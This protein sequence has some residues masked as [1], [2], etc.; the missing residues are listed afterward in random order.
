MIHGGFD[1]YSKRPSAEEPAPPN[2]EQWAGLCVREVLFHNRSSRLRAA[3]T[4]QSGMRSL[5]VSCLVPSPAHYFTSAALNQDSH[6]EFSAEVSTAGVFCACRLMPSPRAGHGR[7]GAFIGQSHPF[8]PGRPTHGVGFECVSRPSD[9]N[10]T[11]VRKSIARNAMAKLSHEELGALRLLAQYPSGCTEAV[12]PVHGVKLD[13]IAN[14]VFRGLAK[15]E[16]SI[17]TIGGRQ[18]KIVRMQITAAGLKAI[19]D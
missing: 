1:R 4:R 14:L 11:R 12:I 19:A 10:I 9:L 7:A 13:R 8:S 3:K 6:D 2:C 5:D 17:V 15:R 18:V 16:V